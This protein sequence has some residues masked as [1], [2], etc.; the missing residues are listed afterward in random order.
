MRLTRG[1]ARVVAVAGFALTITSW[2]P[3]AAAGS[4]GNFLGMAGADGSRVEAASPGFLLVEQADAGAPAAQALLDSVGRSTAYAGYP[5]PGQTALTAA[6][7]GGVPASAYPLAVT[8]NFP[9][10]G[11]VSADYGPLRLV[12]TSA[13]AASSST[14]VVEGTGDPAV[15]AH[16]SAETAVSCTEGTVTSEAVSRANGLSFG[17]GVLRVGSVEAMARVT[18][19]S[20]AD[21][22]V[23]HR[24][25]ITSVTVAGQA[26]AIDQRGLV[27]G[28][29][30]TPLGAAPVQAVLAEA[31]LDVSYVAP[32]EQPDGRGATAPAIRVTMAREAVGT[33]STT[34]TYTFGRAFAT[35]D[36]SPSPDRP[37]PT[38]GGV[39]PSPA[40]DEPPRAAPASP[41]MTT[42]VSVPRPVTERPVLDA[43]LPEFA[44]ARLGFFVSS[45]SFYLVLVVGA[46]AL[47]TSAALVRNL[48]VKLTWI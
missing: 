42:T 8:S 2:S 31:G 33:G 10:E 11:D 28:A 22:V 21:P 44:G 45:W 46:T 38:A 4:C 27:V 6:G 15:A 7:L 19:A 12:A 9:T 23:E 37:Q 20:D 39:V 16:T 36:G 17:D 41:L 13:E 47:L 35:V 34:V 32:I 24:L 48:G 18:R 5:H 3:V 30:T 40:A 43:A 14:A 26:V 29:L 25:E 1:A